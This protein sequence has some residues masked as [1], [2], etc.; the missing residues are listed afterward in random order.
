MDLFL[1]VAVAAL[2]SLAFGHASRWLVLRYGTWS[3]IACNFVG[4]T[5]MILLLDDPRWM[6][7][8][9]AIG[10]GYALG[11]TIPPLTPPRPV[12]EDDP[13]GPAETPGPA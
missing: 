6:P 13:T 9:F 3:R 1:A 7:V 5:P 11:A 4:L 8:A 10:G 2:V 12:P